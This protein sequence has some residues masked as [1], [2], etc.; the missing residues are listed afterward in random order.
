MMDMVLDVIVIKISILRVL[1]KFEQKERL[2]D[3][4]LKTILS[5]KRL[6]TFVIY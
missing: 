4:R 5:N 2:Y 6:N 1:L 3:K